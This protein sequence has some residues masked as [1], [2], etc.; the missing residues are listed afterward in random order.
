MKHKLFAGFAF[1]GALLL[2][3]C[4]RVVS[5]SEKPDSTG[6]NSPIGSEVEPGQPST[7]SGDIPEIPSSP[8]TNPGTVPEV[9]SIPNSHPNVEPSV[10]STQPSEQEPVELV[11]A[12]K[13]T[14]MKYDTRDINDQYLSYGWPTLNTTGNQKVLV[15][16]VEFKD[17]PKWTTSMLQRLDTA[18]FGAAEDTSWHSVRSYYE[19]SSYHQLHLSG[20][21][22]G[23]T[24]G[25]SVLSLSSFTIATA[26]RQ[27]ED[28]VDNIV[29][30]QFDYSNCLSDAKRREYDQDGDGY[31]DATLF[32]YSHSY[33]GSDDAYADAYW[34]WC[35]FLSPE[36][37]RERPMPNNHMW[38]S[39][40]F[41]DDGYGSYTSTKPDAHTYIH[42][43][44]HIL[45]L[46][47]LYNGSYTG[48]DPVGQ[49]EM[50]SY[51]VGDHGA[52][53][54]LALNWA[55][56]YVVTGE[57]TLDIRSSSEYGD[58]IVLPSK[59]L[60]SSAAFN[61]FDEYLLLEFYTPTGLNE[62][63]AKNSYGGRRKMYQI[64]GVRIYHVDTRLGKITWKTTQT[65]SSN[66]YDMVSSVNYT[67]N[68]GIM[69]YDNYFYY[70]VGSNTPTNSFQKSNFK[71]LELMQ[72]CGRNLFKDGTSSYSDSQILFTKKSTFT[73]TSAFFTKGNQTWNR[74]TN[75]GYTIIIDDIT[76]EKA[77]ISFKKA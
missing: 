63:D 15:V 51:N 11:N 64:P 62:K 50:Q 32:V 34:A 75:I 31:I 3:S 46:D 52:F 39:Y 45:G 77:T 20:E 13:A 66:V 53:D 29:S 37:S 8:S 28:I 58:F 54:K 68:L 41:M 10:P 71:Y 69:S 26:A 27:G 19:E 22:L 36:P 21:V 16:P 44:G 14:S 23:L 6:G 35:Y 67:D 76:S 57:T 9:P 24:S 17:G 2:S 33:A 40:D 72:A 12:Y 61:P 18:M 42:E 49:S 73:P 65:S 60:S 56:P 48:Y 5:N 4:N 25:T 47:D 59:P 70:P 38:A 74:G 7:D 30:V 1:I 43:F 55:T